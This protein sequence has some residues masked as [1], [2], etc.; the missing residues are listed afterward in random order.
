MISGDG[1]Y[2]IAVVIEA[3][4]DYDDQ[5][6]WNGFVTKSSNEYAYNNIGWDAL[7]ERDLCGDWELLVWGSSTYVPCKNS[8]VSDASKLQRSAMQKT[9]SLEE[10]LD[11]MIVKEP[12]YDLKHDTILVF[13]SGVDYVW[14]TYSRI[15]SN[16]LNQE[17]VHG[18]YSFWSGDRGSQ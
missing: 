17:T 12:E 3:L 8:I 6:S 13:R 18:M 1:W 14:G 5:T 15:D 16:C 2:K 9:T 4:A 7:I 11:T 10:V